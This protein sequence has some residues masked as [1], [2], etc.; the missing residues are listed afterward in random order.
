MFNIIKYTLKVWATAL[1]MAPVIIVASGLMKSFNINDALGMIMFG[2][3]I[4]AIYSL[5]SVALLAIATCFIAK[6]N[7]PLLYKKAVL[8]VIGIVL[9][10][11]AF[12]IF[13]SG[14]SILFEELSWDR[15]VYATA[16]IAGIWFYRLTPQPARGRTL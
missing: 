8:T 10:M 3:L 12:I 7:M 4:G 5:P 14:K 1:F 11:L 6:Y 15:A 9:T 16:I 13:N 2:I